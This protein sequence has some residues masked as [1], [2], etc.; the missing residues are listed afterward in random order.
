LLGTRLTSKSA[1]Y[2]TLIRDL[3][4]LVPMSDNTL[5][6]PPQFLG[7][8]AGPGGDHCA[9]VLDRVEPAQRA[10][11]KSPRN[12]IHTFNRGEKSYRQ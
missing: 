12:H 3:L 7:C 4:N 9:H 1:D 10:T 5:N 6:Q 11:F 2:A 8:D